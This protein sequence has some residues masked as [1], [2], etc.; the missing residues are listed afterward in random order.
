V[1]AEAAARD[2]N[3][4]EHAAHI[5]EDPAVQTALQFASRKLSNTRCQEVFADFRDPAGRTLANK[6]ETLGETAGSY[7][8]LIQFFDAGE[9]GPCHAGLLLAFTVPGSRAVYLCGP[10]FRTRVRQSP[11]R[12]AAVLIH[13]EL[14][15][16][17]LGEDPPSSAEITDRVLGRCGV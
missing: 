10:R 3:W 6:L 5:R 2:G 17:G 12:A 1:A 4:Q 7:L 11:G 16:L 14:H 15:S 8:T 13:E 9:E